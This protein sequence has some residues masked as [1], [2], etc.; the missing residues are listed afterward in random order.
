MAFPTLER[1]VRVA[2]SPG[3]RIAAPRYLEVTYDEADVLGPPGPF[4]A[5][6]LAHVTVFAEVTP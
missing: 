6:S 3:V 5:L 1:A 2:L 4:G